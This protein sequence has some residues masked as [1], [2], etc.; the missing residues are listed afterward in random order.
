MSK[1]KRGPRGERCD[2]CYFYS[3][4]SKK[5]LEATR[6]HGHCHTTPEGA[7][8][9]EHYW[10]RDFLLQ[11][12]PVLVGPILPKTGLNFREA[13]KMYKKSLY[14]QALDM[15]DGDKGRAADLLR[16]K[17]TTYVEALRRIDK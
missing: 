12:S 3:P 5:D 10:C 11:G 7:F 4:L 16:L 14:L 6:Y 2:E 1:T 15:T 8:V 17:R 13:V 9:E